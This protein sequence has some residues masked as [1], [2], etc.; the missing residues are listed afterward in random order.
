MNII[1]VISIQN[2]VLF[3][4]TSTMISYFSFLPEKCQVKFTKDTN[5]IELKSE[6][7]GVCNVIVGSSSIK[8]T[9]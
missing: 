3:N 8:D 6:D 1:N 7:V 2:L 9:C 5:I 4:Y